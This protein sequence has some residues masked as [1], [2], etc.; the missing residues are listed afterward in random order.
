MKR[1]ITV[2]DALLTRA[3]RIANEEEVRLVM[4]FRERP[5]EA[6]HANAKT[7]RL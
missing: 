1:Q 2:V 6:R 7:A 4:Q 5:G 3:M